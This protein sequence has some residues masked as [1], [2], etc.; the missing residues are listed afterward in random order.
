MLRPLCI[1]LL[2]AIPAALTGCK[3]GDGERCQVLAD[4]QDGLVCVLPPGGS[5]QTGG[6]CRSNEAA[7]MATDAP[8][9]STNP[10][11]AGVDLSTHD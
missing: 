10:D 2:F 8:D 1:A 5:P 3:Q 4:C 7:D 11:L 9:L 6:I